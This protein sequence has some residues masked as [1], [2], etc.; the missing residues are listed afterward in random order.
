MA[1]L[2]RN[3][4]KRARRLLLREWAVEEL[5]GCCVGCGTTENLEFDH[6][7]PT[8]KTSTINALIRQDSKRKIAEE[9]D[10]CQLL[11]VECHKDKSR[12]GDYNRRALSKAQKLA[13]GLLHRP[14][15]RVFGTNALARAYN[16]GQSSIKHHSKRDKR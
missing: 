5:G 11:C 13:V 3:E 7:D 4:K 2:T 16:V 10:N 14:G 6:I 15:S 1:N 8:K 9:L 12:E